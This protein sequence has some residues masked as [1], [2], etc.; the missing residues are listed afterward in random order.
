MEYVKIRL[1]EFETYM[2]V[3][4]PQPPIHTERS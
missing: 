1:I 2:V 4:L 3:E